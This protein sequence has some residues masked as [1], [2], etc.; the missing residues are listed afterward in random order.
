[1]L[2]AREIQD[3]FQVDRSTVYRMAEDG[4]LPAIKIGKQWRFPAEQIN[5]WF[6]AQMTTSTGLSD[7]PF[8]QELPDNRRQELADLLSWDWLK[9]G[10][11]RRSG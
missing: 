4:R 10:E 5:N 3:L 9:Y 6:Q 7:W 11:D 2:T 1:M 8:V